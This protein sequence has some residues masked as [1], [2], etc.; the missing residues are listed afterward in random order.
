MTETVNT[1]AE[2]VD[3]SAPIGTAAASPIT[4]FLF[5][6]GILV[7]ASMLPYALIVAA[8]GNSTAALIVAIIIVVAILAYSAFRR[9]RVA[10]GLAFQPEDLAIPAPPERDDASELF[11]KTSPDEGQPDDS[12]PV[13][14]KQRSR[15]FR[16]RTSSASDAPEAPHADSVDRDQGL[17]PE[18]TAI[19]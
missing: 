12:Q 2:A 5:G 18:P 8:T 10:R 17:A 14:A 6:L 11:F 4:R 19:K 16:G 13:T 1:E 3:P 9:S 15:W 7:F